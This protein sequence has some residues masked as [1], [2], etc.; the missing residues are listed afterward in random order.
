MSKTLRIALG[1]TLVT[2]LAAPQL[3]AQLS[4]NDQI[5]ARARVVAPVT[6]TAGQDLDFGA[7]LQNTSSLVDAQN[8]NSGSFVVTGTNGAGIDL[9]WV[10]P[11]LLVSG[12]NNMTIDTYSVIRGDNASR[13]TAITDN[14]ATGGTPSEVDFL[15]VNNYNVFVGASVTAAAA[16]PV[17]LYTA[18]IQLTVTYNG[19]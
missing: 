1:L 16:Q 11:T 2:A 19:T 12:G 15:G 3:Q 18:N 10:L 9:D 17:G 6:V 13:A 14:Y 7:V 8:A 4:D 5:T